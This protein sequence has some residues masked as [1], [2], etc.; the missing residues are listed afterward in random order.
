W[1]ARLWPDRRQH[2]RRSPLMVRLSL[3]RALLGAAAVF[4]VAAP[5]SAE[6]VAITNA[7]VLTGTS[8]IENGTVVFDGARIVPL[9][10]GAAPARVG[11]PAPASAAVLAIAAARALT[12]TSVTADGTVAFDGARTVSGGAGAAPAGARSSDGSGKPV[13]PGFVAADSGLGGSEVSS[14]R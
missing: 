14:V 9:G 12:G 5:A 10:A 8:V 3:K 7:R 1:P 13:S 4:A 11:A 2:E 6:V